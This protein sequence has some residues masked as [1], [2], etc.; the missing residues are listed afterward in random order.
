M[1]TFPEL[2]KE[3]YENLTKLDEDWMKSADGKER[4]RKFIISYVL[5]VLPV[6]FSCSNPDTSQV[7]KED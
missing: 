1:E 4:W 2:A 5:G 7:R 3:P 6:G